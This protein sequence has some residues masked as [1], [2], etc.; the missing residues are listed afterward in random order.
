[1]P[2]RL[3]WAIWRTVWPAR[4]IKGARGGSGLDSQVA[5]QTSVRGF[6]GAACATAPK[7]SDV[8]SAT[9]NAA[10]AQGARGRREMSDD[11]RAGARFAKHHSMFPDPH[12]NDWTSRRQAA[13]LVNLTTLTPL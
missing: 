11:D 6:G 13:A 4:V 3:T 10:G 5:A 9:A 8:A 12:R 1:M 2:P 7:I